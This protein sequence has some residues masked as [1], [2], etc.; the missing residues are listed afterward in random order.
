[1]WDSEQK[2]TKVDSSPGG[3][4]SGNYHARQYERRHSSINYFGV[5]NLREGL[6]KG[7]RLPLCCENG[8]AADVDQTFLK[9]IAR[10]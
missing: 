7:R 1:M 9:R 3:M 5:K 10:P 6:I 2:T 8:V 4:L